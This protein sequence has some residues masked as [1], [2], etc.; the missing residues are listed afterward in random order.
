MPG[1]TA[2]WNEEVFTLF[3]YLVSLPESHY[4]LAKVG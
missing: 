4:S 2:S 3:A 1:W